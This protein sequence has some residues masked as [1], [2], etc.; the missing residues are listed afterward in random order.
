LGKRSATASR[1]KNHDRGL[2]FFPPSN[3]FNVEVEW[4][5]T[6]QILRNVRPSWIGDDVNVVKH[7]I[8]STSGIPASG[9]A[10]MDSLMTA[11]YGR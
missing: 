10:A 11:T 4:Y 8:L 9:V 5:Q 7:E 3:S 2:P 6:E 1:L